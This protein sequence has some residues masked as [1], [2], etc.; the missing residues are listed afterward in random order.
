M[1]QFSQLKKEALKVKREEQKKKGEEVSAKVEGLTSAKKKLVEK[2]SW[3]IEDY[4]AYQTDRA[5][6]D[7]CKQEVY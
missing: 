2:D 5:K 1:E 3:A 7:R 6:A 4:E